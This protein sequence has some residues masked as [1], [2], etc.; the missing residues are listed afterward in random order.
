MTGLCPRYDVLVIG[1]GPTGLTCA[2]ILGMYGIRTLVVERNAA[3]VGEP[4]AVSIDDES[5]RTMQFIDLVDA[6]RK[7]ISEGYG[8]YYYSPRRRCF[9]KVVPDTMEYGFPRRS[10]FRQPILEA[11]LRAGLERFPTVATRFSTRVT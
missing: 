1:A 6:V 5:L 8:S 2:N 3:T 7:D 10:A 9:A 4:R 11:Q